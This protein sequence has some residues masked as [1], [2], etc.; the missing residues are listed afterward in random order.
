V[1]S[2]FNE[3]NL[4]RKDIVGKAFDGIANMNGLDTKG[5]LKKNEDRVFPALYLLPLR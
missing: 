3:L 1:K 2:A 4:D 5:T